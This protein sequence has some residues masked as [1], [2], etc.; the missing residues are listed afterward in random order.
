VAG[1]KKG[2]LKRLSSSTFALPHLG[3]ARC[4]ALYGRGAEARAAAA[5]GRELA[6][7]ATRRERQQVEAL[8]LVI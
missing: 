4:L 6:V 3:R 2:V 7:S 8:A 1:S 5:R